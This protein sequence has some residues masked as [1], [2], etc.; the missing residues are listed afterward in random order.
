MSDKEF[1]MECPVA[2]WVPVSKM[3]RMIS[4][5]HRVCE[6][7]LSF[8]RHFDQRTMGPTPDILYKL[9]GIAPHHLTSNLHIFIEKKTEN[10]SAQMTYT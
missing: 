8:A 7:I 9:M 4:H 1:L 10:S 5:F 3:K 6:I 2:V